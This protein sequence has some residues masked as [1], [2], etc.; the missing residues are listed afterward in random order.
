MWRD[1]SLHADLVRKRSKYGFCPYF[2]L[3]F[4]KGEFTYIYGIYIREEK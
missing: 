1:K 3:F 4:E 2:D